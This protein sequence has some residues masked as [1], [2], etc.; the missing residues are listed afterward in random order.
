MQKG[1]SDHIFYFI[2]VINRRKWLFVL[3]ILLVLAYT[4]FQAYTT[5]PLF[6]SQTRIVSPPNPMLI[7]V[8]QDPQAAYLNYLNRGAHF[9]NEIEYVTRDEFC[10]RIFPKLPQGTKDY[11]LSQSTDSTV[12]V[13]GSLRVEHA[14]NGDV[15]VLTSVTPNANA[16]ADIANAA[17]DEYL[18][19]VVERYRATRELVSSEV[20]L[21]M[22]P[23]IEE[24]L[25]AAKEER[26]RF[27]NSLGFQNI[28]ETSNATTIKWSSMAGKVFDLEQKLRDANTRKN[29]VA[30]LSPLEDNYLQIAYA[31][32]G[33]DSEVIKK[34]ASDR[35]NHVLDL[36]LLQKRYKDKAPPIKNVKDKIGIIDQAL[37][38]EIQNYLVN[39]DQEMGIV[40]AQLAENTKWRDD[41][42]KEVNDINQ[43]LINLDGLE[44]EIK[45][46]ESQYAY[47]KGVGSEAGI[48][49]QANTPVV[50]IIQKASAAAAPFKPDIKLMFLIGS[51]VALTIGI[52]LC[53]L[54]ENFDSSIRYPEEL[55][56]VFGSI[57]VGVIPLLKV[58]QKQRKPIIIQKSDSNAFEALRKLR[59]EIN[60]Y[61]NKT[62]Y[63]VFS[64]LSSSP[65][66]GKTTVALNIAYALSLDGKSVLLIDAD[67]RR[68]TLYQIGVKDPSDALMAYLKGQVGV[69][70]MIT[71]TIYDN[72]YLIASKNYFSDSPEILSSDKFKQ[73]I[74]Y[75][76]QN[77]D[78][79]I[80][81]TPP[82]LSLT[83]GGIVAKITDASFIIVRESY[84]KRAYVYS[85][86]RHLNN[87]NINLAG[88]VLNCVKESRSYY[89]YYY[90]YTYYYN[91]YYSK[92][93]SLEGAR[94]DVESE[95]ISKKD[96]SEPPIIIT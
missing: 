95:V 42:E 63:N 30:S 72:V 60:F 65:L 75:G 53:F 71:P 6:M 90:Y 32:E 80:V 70:G 89:Y 50:R 23:K 77:F 18:L 48:S 28:K 11:I 29:T 36:E 62:S 5:T 14:E 88:I 68:P 34:L 58:K 3:V 59:T 84:T 16:C 4:A 1:L 51:I 15:L 35:K 22:I 82:L 73:I 66:E 9:Q 43:K 64:V 56:K 69:Q 39:L 7:P 13:M 96:D 44:Q 55:E 45:I 78:V 40:K 67:L 92:Y 46:L 25:N 81:D 91:R 57:I 93:Y 83:D 74:D 20:E 49:S 94:D 24:K 2:Q 47:Y 27:L 37:V 87:L 38:R 76:R 41:L 21:N 86:Q 85:V 8:K 52:G 33:K 54:L 12:Y 61:M 26:L 10:K 31:I 17:S 19:S 79:V